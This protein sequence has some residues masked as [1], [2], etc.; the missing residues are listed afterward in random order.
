[1][2]EF[3][4]KWKNFI[5]FCYRLIAPI[6]DPLKFFRGIYGYCWFCAD[7]I[8]YKMRGGRERIFTINLF[9]QVHDKT[10]L[11]PFEIHNFFQEPWLFERVMTN[12]PAQHV[13]IGSTY[14]LCGYLSKIIPTVFLDIRPIDRKMKNLSVLAGDILKLPL[15]NNAVVSL[16]CLHVIEHVGLGRYGDEINPGG[17]E[18]ACRELAR[19]LK[20]GG[21]LYVTTPIGRDRLCFNSHRVTSVA[22]IKEYFGNLEILEFSLVDDAGSFHENV[23]LSLADTMHYALGLFVFTKK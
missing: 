12:R 11:T 9:P 18:Q 22:K 2:K 13:D 4:S 16:S 19:V 20:P 1:M 17:M 14:T 15:E 8:K 7:V 10:P 6:F 21:R 23:A 3:K 5:Y